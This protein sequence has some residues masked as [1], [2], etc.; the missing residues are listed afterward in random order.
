MDW[1]ATIKWVGNLPPTATAE[2]LKQWFD[3]RCPPNTVAC[4]KIVNCNGTIIPSHAF[5]E[6]VTPAI[7][8]VGI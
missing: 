4:V 2:K 8:T 5:V 3:Q 6:F 7:A 1:L